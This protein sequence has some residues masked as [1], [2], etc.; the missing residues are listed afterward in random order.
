M[1]RQA[2]RAGPAAGNEI[3]RLAHPTKPWKMW[4]SK[5]F[6]TIHAETVSLPSIGCTPKGSYGKHS[7]SKKGSEKVLGQGSQKGS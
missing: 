4:H 6:T 5:D 1:M 3:L 2:S 7:V